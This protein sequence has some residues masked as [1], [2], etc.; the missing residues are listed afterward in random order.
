MANIEKEFGKNLSLAALFQGAT[1]EQL[2][3]LLR[4]NT[5]THSWSPLVAIQ[6]QGSQPPFFCMPGSGGNVV[7]FH[8]LARHLGNEQPFYALQP[9]SLDGVSEPFSCPAKFIPHLMLRI[10][11]GMN[12]AQGMYGML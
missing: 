10:R 6:P 1:V 7:Y 5:D 3:I 9:P 11:C 2:G 4:Q 8:Q 12:F